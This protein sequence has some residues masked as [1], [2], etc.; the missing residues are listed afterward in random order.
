MCA[1]FLHGCSGFT[2][3]VSPSMKS[4]KNDTAPV[5]SAGFLSPNETNDPY[6]KKFICKFRRLVRIF[7]NSET[8][9]NYVS[10]PKERTERSHKLEEMTAI[11]PK[12]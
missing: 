6:V 11:V 4:R 9:S 3:N 10:N 1:N 8:K 2:D 12:K 7:I 5:S